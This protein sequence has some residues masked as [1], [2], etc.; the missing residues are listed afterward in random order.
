MLHMS[1]LQNEL[2]NRGFPHVRA[3]YI[4]D[5]EASGRIPPA[6]RDWQGRRLFDD[7]HVAAIAE[8]L[9]AKR[10]QAA[11]RKGR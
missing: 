1:E 9:A 2:A 4:R 6:N 11:P 5:L 3:P 8:R 10:K 7:S